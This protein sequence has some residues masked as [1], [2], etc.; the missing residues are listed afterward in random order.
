MPILR[1]SLCST[2]L[3]ALTLL[4]STHAVAAAP[5]DLGHGVQRYAMAT[6]FEQCFG[7]QY[8]AGTT[9]LSLEGGRLS[10]SGPDGLMAEAELRRVRRFE[11][12]LPGLN[13]LSGAAAMAYV[14]GVVASPHCRQPVV[15]LHTALQTPGG[16]E[17]SGFA[18]LAS[19]DRLAPLVTFARAQASRDAQAL[20]V[21]PPAPAGGA[22]L[23]ASSLG[24]RLAIHEGL[25]PPEF[26]GGCV[27]HARYE[28]ALERA[29]T[30]EVLCFSVVASAWGAAAIACGANPACELAATIGALVGFA[31]CTFRRFA[32][33]AVAR[34]NFEDCMRD[35]LRFEP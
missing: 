23:A 30:Q 22:D 35:C 31:Q 4:T 15:G 2:V 28:A 27:C 7:V 1:S 9:R 5:L 3:L 19:A 34:E 33:E 29:L 16:T 25:E 12:R 6:L 10:V 14:V 11:R 32:A 24:A 26:G 17:V 8:E 20:T 13:R 21:E 18:V